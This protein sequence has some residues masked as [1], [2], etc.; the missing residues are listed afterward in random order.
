[1]QNV[2]DA[3]DFVSWGQTTAATETGPAPVT[4]QTVGFAY[5]DEAVLSD[6]NLDLEAGT[7]LAVVGPTASGKSTL[8][9]LLARLWDPDAGSIHL[10][11]RDLRQF[12]RSELPKEVAYVSQNAFRGGATQWSRHRAR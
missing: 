10:A 1:V 7:T 2:L 5:D 8:G 9:L 11:G 3:D 6:L 12:A 4:G